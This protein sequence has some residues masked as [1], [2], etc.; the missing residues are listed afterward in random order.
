MKKKSILNTWLWKWHF[1]AGLISLP[2]VLILS[3]TGAIYLFKSDYET[4]RQK[5]IKEVIVQETS[6][7]FQEQWG[8]ANKNAIKKP[9]TIII[10]TAPNQ[11]TEFVS[12]RFGG[13]SSLY[14]NPYTGN[15][16]GEIIGKKTDM[17]LV[18]KLHG[19]L[20]MGAFGTKIIELIASWMVVLILTGL[21][22]WWPQNKW[23]IKGYF[24]PRTNIDRRTFY[25]DI[26]A[27]SG[28]WISV[29]LLMILA[30]GFPWTDVFGN[31]FKQ[32]QKITNTGYPASWQGKQ[33]LSNPLENALTLD[34]MVAK[35]KELQLPGQVSLSFPR[36]PKGVFSVS[37]FNPSNLSSQQKIHF[38]QYSG[39]QIAHLT[40]KDVGVLMRGRMWFMAFHQGEFGNWNWWL[41]FFTAV[42]LAI[43]S[44]SAIASY[45]LRKR[46]K[47][48]G[49]PKVP[50][51]F[52]LGYGIILVL[53]I[54]SIIFPL[55]GVSLLLIILVEYLKRTSQKIKTLNT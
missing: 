5:H 16:S 13:K 49:V 9:N 26:H 27:I 21:Y 52:K 12:G 51:S 46:K 39:A 20:L 10:P 50:A 6:L 29:L 53:L 31:N 36:G 48:W 3:I 24:I 4:P 38:D 7:S 37:N 22:V 23:A 43:M 18:R 35:A 25:R 42:I 55:F 2:F 15:V 41:M 40:W 28:F 17:Y 32:V 44:L 19:E 47:S 54:L 11:A 8:I 30:G 45:I 33:L 1:I 14:I 34:Q